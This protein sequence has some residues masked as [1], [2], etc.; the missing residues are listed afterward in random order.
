MPRV[1]NKECW[2][3][4]EDKLYTISENRNCKHIAEC[5]L[6]ISILISAGRDKD[7]EWINSNM[8][9]FYCQLARLYIEPTRNLVLA[10]LEH[11]HGGKQSIFKESILES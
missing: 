10:T 1:T 5:K 3:I 2:D 8:F 11:I 6:A 7:I 4:L 9:N